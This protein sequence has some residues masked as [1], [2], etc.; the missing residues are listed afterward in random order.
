MGSAHLDLLPVGRNS[1]AEPAATNVER[2]LGIAH[3]RGPDDSTGLAGVT[4]CR[5]ASSY[6]PIGPDSELRIVLSDL[7][8]ATFV[9][10]ETTS[11][12]MLDLREV[13]AK[14]HEVP[15]Y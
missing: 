8:P 5:V 4:V 10:V 11:Q 12:T 14:R 15:T 7:L 13:W 1:S 9:V 2:R 6:A 3:V